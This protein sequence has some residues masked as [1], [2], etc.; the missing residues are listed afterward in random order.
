[1]GDSLR[2]IRLCTG[3][4]LSALILVLSASGSANSQSADDAK[5]KALQAQID[6]LQR[7]VNEL[8]AAQSQTANEAK[9][10]KK[11]ASEAEAQAANAKATAADAHAKSHKAPAIL[12][13]G[14]IDSN[15]HR[16]LEKKPGK[17]LTFYTPGGEI[18]AYGQL[19]VSFDGATKDAKG[20]PVVPDNTLI[21]TPGSTPV[22]N[23]GWMAD[24]STNISYLGV[25]GFQ[26]L[27]MHDFNF[28]YQFEAGI[29]ISV[30]PGTKQTNSNLS[31]QVNGAL[32]S[33]N[34]YI[35][36]ASS[37]WGA[38]KIGKTDAP[39]KNSTAMFNPFVGTWGDYA[40]IMGNS[41]GDNRVEF[42]TRVSHAIWYESPKFGGFQFNL[43][44]SP[45][46]NRAN[47]SSNLASG[48]SDCAGNNDP[49]SG[50]NPLVSCSDGAF[51]NAVSTNLSYTNGPLYMTGAAEWHQNVNRQSDLAGAYGVPLP[52]FG[53]A[54]D[55]SAF[56][57]LDPTVVPN[58]AFAQQQ[59]IEDVANEWAAKYGI[60]YT[61][62]TRTTVGGI[63][64]YL[65]R[66]VPADLAF[67]NERTRW[68]TWFVVSQELTHDDSL[69]FGWAHAFRSPGNPGQ[70]ND[71]TLITANGAVFGPTQNQSDMVTAE[72]K[73]KF[74]EN[75]IWYSIAAATFN[76][77]DAHYDLG[78]GGRSVTTD[79]HDAAFAPGGAFSNPHCWTGTTLV[80]LSTGLQWKF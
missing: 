34:S 3:V 5:L 25:R 75:L 33:R 66:D 23:F 22:G 49:T 61:F 38:I 79:C 44:F 50:A 69:H 10:A 26:R 62:P 32:F 68:G 30:T 58:P 16:F 46:Q 52:G 24:I 47:D 41:G 15:G 48:E 39:Y 59:C 31:N 14:D 27:P 70:H 71:T 13:L 72:W 76:G 1:M 12:G 11:Q 67:Q 40:V 29:D 77:P 56:L 19:D 63:V 78:A 42:G 57:L 45:G 64:E 35:G 53:G 73:H 65:H 17:D 9:A 20:L 60:M 55:C 7:T 8:K 2:R 6:Q 43:L 28:V 4:S 51:S 18:T 21:S 80:G 37:Q 36:L 54:Q 74:S